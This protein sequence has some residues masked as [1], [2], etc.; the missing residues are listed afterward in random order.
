MGG[1]LPVDG[2]KVIEYRITLG[3]KERQMLESFVNSQ[4][5]NQIVTPTVAALS[6]VS[7]VVLIGGFLASMG[8]I[9]EGYWTSTKQALAEGKEDAASLLGKIG[10]GIEWTSENARNLGGSGRSFI[11]NFIEQITLGRIDFD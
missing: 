2:T 8:F 7:F 1:R 3:T 5:F 6:D 4:N 9:E 10:D 11:E